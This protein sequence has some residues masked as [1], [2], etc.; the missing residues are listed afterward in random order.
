[1]EAIPKKQHN[2]KRIALLC[3]CGVFAVILIAVL[4]HYRG[5]RMIAV[6][7]LGTKITARDFTSRN[8]TLDGGDEKLLRGWH[9]RILRI[10]GCP[11]PVLVHVV[12]TAAPTAEPVPQTVPLGKELRPDAFVSGIKDADIVRVSFETVPDFHS[13][14]KDVIRIV[15][16]DGSGNQSTVSVP[17]SVRASVESLSLEAGSEL[18]SA[19]R[20]LLEGVKAE[21]ITPP[22]PSVMHHA[23]V[24]QILFRTAEGKE[25][26][27]ELIVTDTVAPQ[28]DG[29]LL[30]CTPDETVQPSDFVVNASDETDLTYTYVSE[31]DYASRDLQTVVVRVTD[32]GG[33]SCEVEGRLLV[34]GIRPKEIEARS[35]ALTPD[36]FDNLDG[37]NIETEPF[38]PD[39]PG[40]YAVTV[41]VNGV[42]EIMAITVVDTTPPVLR[43]KP[44]GNTTL[45]TCHNYRPED[46]FEAED[47][48]PVSL[49]FAQ[50]PNQ[51]RAGR[52]NITVLA[53]DAAGN[54]TVASRA[55][56]LRKDSKAPQ[57]Y[58][59]M[60]R[61]CYVGEPIA[62]LSDVF[63]EDEVDGAVEVTVESDVDI[64]KTGTYRVVFYA[65][66]RTGN[67]TK[68]VCRYQLIENT[69]TEEELHAM[70]QQ[71]M[72]EIT[73][74]D[75]V[76][77]EKLRAIF[78]YV[79]G[80][81]KYTN[82]SNHNYTDWR[83]AAYDGYR[84]GKGDC[85]NIYALTRALLDETDI[86]YLSVERVKSSARRTR[87]YWVN[88][89]L[90][91]GW[92]CFDPTKT[93]RHRI[94]CF[95]WTKERCSYYN[96]YWLFNQKNYPPMAKEPFDY[97]KVVQMERDGLLP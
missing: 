23:G 87:H 67:R 35:T 19:D 25:S 60:D 86:Q 10:G 20:F 43:E 46:F 2:R 88:V 93:P 85:F 77:A 5:V 80:R 79:Q 76:N 71:I 89:N 24:Y 81:I 34:S 54:E 37:Q 47:Y 69:V 3:V 90:G 84:Q 14:W 82:G 57:I 32:E 6:S 17:V 75:M 65:Q 45:Y 64:Q 13:E 96:N 15:L 58:G 11:T 29:T 62:Y 18:P 22:D 59:A 7:E 41:A 52:V 28:A 94:D 53:R 38:V 4:I 70:A 8:A 50:E 66:D 92:Y 33:N 26:R 42:P 83:K 27:S 12:D 72:N 73:T 39:T 21:Q 1:M 97:D 55:V 40:V 49:T 51:Q 16:E 44:L 30:H 91:T 31:P 56:Y 36:D 95:M 48:S 78:D 63:A 68:I 74:P 9:M 61:I